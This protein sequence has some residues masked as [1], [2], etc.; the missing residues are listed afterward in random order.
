MSGPH[1]RTIMQLMRTP[2]RVETKANALR[3]RVAPIVARRIPIQ[4]IARSPVP[5]S[6]GRRLSRDVHVRNPPHSHP[7]RITVRTPSAASM[8]LAPALLFT[9]LGQLQ[10]QVGAHPAGHDHADHDEAVAGGGKI[11]A[12]WTA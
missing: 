9:L 5:G 11:P 3:M 1:M 6:Q 8:L 10:A 4:C 12:G 2:T 7:S